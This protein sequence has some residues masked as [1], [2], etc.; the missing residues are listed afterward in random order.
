M[1]ELGLGVE[2]MMYGLTGVF[3]VL[4]MF[5]FVIKLLLKVFPY[6]EETK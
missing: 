3:V 4:I 6:K 5:Y 2:L 1:N